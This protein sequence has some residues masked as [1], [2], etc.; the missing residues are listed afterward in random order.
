MERDRVPADPRPPVF[1]IVCKNTQIADVIYEMARRGRSRPRESRPRR[2]TV[3]EYATI[4][5]YTIRVDSKV[6]A[7]D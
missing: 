1:I 6:V 5:Q 3:S 2:S 7:R 4:E